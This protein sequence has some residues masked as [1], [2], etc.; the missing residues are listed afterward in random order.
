MSAGSPAGRPRH[1]RRCAQTG[2][3]RM[4]YAF[5]AYHEEEDVQSWSDEED[6]A[7]MGELNGVHERLTAEGRLGPAAR[8]GSTANALTLRGRGL[9]T[10]GPPAETQEQLSGLHV[11]HCQIPEPAATAA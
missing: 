6:A 8:L 10:D 9:V 5:L 3:Q 7:L 11:L 4:L 2:I 1:A